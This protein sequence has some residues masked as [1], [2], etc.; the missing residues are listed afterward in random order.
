MRWLITHGYM[1][2]SLC[3]QPRKNQREQSQKSGPLENLSRFRRKLQRLSLTGCGPP[4]RI[5]CDPKYVPIQNI[6]P[7]K[8]NIRTSL[9]ISVGKMGRPLPRRALK[10]C[11]I[12]TRS[13]AHDALQLDCTPL[14]PFLLF[15]NF[16]LQNHYPQKKDQGN[17][18][19]FGNHP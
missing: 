14:F 15:C 5:R 11:L 17:P 13:H 9:R 16:Q 7:P 18:S 2:H 4:T 19:G 6:K 1:N 3:N 8:E 12:N 10:A